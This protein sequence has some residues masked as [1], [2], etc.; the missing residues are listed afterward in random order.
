ML[1]RPPISTRTDT[2]FPYTTLFRSHEVEHRL[3][4][5]RERPALQHAVPTMADMAFDQRQ[6]ARNPGPGQRHGGEIA[7]AIAERDVRAEARLAVHGRDIMR[8]E[9]SDDRFVKLADPAAAAR[10]VELGSR[11]AR[12]EPAAVHPAPPRQ[13]RVHALFPP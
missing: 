11:P 9:P 12:H 1:Q 6:L 13:A 2:L 5:R 10:G 8:R 7:F 3:R 4:R